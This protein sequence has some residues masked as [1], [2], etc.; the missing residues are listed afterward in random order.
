M[1]LPIRYPERP[2]KREYEDLFSGEE[3]K[4]GQIGPGFSGAFNDNLSSEGQAGFTY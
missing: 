4:N 1:F 2:K 3:W